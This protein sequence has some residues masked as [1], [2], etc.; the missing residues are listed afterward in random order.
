MPD[1]PVDGCGTC[2]RRGTGRRRQRRYGGDQPPGRQRAPDVSVSDTDTGR[3]LPARRDL[4]DGLRH[5]RSSRAA[6]FRR[7]L[8]RHDPPRIGRC[9]A[10]WLRGPADAGPSAAGCRDGGGGQLDGYRRRQHC[11]PQ[12]TALDRS[13]HGE[14]GAPQHRNPAGAGARTASYCRSRDGRQPA[15]R[16][17]SWTCAR[18]HQAAG[19]R[20]IPNAGLDPWRCGAA[21]R[22][23]RPGRAC[24]GQ[25]H[26]R[27][28]GRSYAIGPGGC[29][30]IGLD[31]K[32][33]GL[34]PATLG[35]RP[36]VRHH[37]ASIQADRGRGRYGRDQAQRPAARTRPVLSVARHV[38]G[39]QGRAGRRAL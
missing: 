38:S 20:G 17:C 34:R 4:V 29:G 25:Y 35:L 21:A 27:A 3:D 1:K 6:G 9:S 8:R 11:Q 13:D 26:C 28:A 5:P 36:S 22:R 19:V 37:R 10:G 39:G 24:A 15:G 2:A 16:H 7:Q 18:L 12:R 31:A 14:C 33:H 32:I 30:A 23:R